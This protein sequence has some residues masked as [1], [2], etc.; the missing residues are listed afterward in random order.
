MTIN[1]R[2]SIAASISPDLVREACVEAKARSA[3]RPEDFYAQL[4]MALKRRVV[5]PLPENTPWAVILVAVDG[6]VR[7]VLSSAGP[8][9]LEPRGAHDDVASGAVSLWFSVHHE[10]EIAPF[11]TRG[12]TKLSATVVETV[13][14]LTST[15]VVVVNC[16]EVVVVVSV[17]VRVLVVDVVR[18]DE[19][20]SKTVLGGQVSIDPSRNW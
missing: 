18:V 17:R 2:E 4:A 7:A 3:G 5:A 11:A 9:F 10:D 1:V 16:V 19:L 20:V 8:R 13:D 15:S 12:T 6:G 14:V